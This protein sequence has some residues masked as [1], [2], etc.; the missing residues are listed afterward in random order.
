MRWVHG[1]VSTRAGRRSRLDTQGS[2]D[3][4]GRSHRQTRGR[5]TKTVANAVVASVVGALRIGLACGVEVTTFRDQTG[6]AGPA[7]H[8]RHTLAR[9]DIGIALSAQSKRSSGRTNRR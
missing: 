2:W 8:T 7:L 4:G 9:G 1:T 5:H 6:V 3:W